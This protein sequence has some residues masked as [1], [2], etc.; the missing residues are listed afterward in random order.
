MKH[1]THL[2]LVVPSRPS[3]AIEDVLKEL[4]EVHALLRLCRESCLNFRDRLER[5]SAMAPVFGELAS[6]AK[7][8]NPRSARAASAPSGSPP[9]P[10]C[11]APRP[12]SG[13]GRIP[14]AWRWSSRQ[15]VTGA[16]GRPSRTSSSLTHCG[17]G[18]V[19]H[20]KAVAITHRSVCT[21]V[22]GGRP[23]R[24]C[25]RFGGTFLDLLARRQRCPSLT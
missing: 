6:L 10:H 23:W 24:A 13:P 18:G 12:P 19:G 3:T 1:P 2:Q 11:A 9:W 4:E 15:I 20:A 17:P 14:N 16:I 7:A 22:A 8:L 25:R 5:L 21:D